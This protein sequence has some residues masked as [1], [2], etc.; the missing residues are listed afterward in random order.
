MPENRGRKR[1]RE[2]EEEGTLDFGGFDDGSDGF[3]QMTSLER[4]LVLTRWDCNSYIGNGHFKPP[5]K[6]AN[7]RSIETLQKK[8]EEPLVPPPKRMEPVVPAPIVVKVEVED[9]NGEMLTDSEPNNAK[10]E[11]EGKE[12]C[13]PPELESPRTPGTEDYDTDVMPILVSEHSN[14][15]TSILDHHNSKSSMPMPTLTPENS[16][17]VITRQSSPSSSNNG[18]Q[19]SSSENQPIGDNESKLGEQEMSI[20]SRLRLAPKMFEDFGILTPF[21]RMLIFTQCGRRGQHSISEDIQGRVESFDDNKQMSSVSKPKRI[22]ETP[23]RN[24]NP[25]S[26]A[27]AT[28]NV[29]SNPAAKKKRRRAPSKAILP[30][31]K[32][33]RKEK[34]ANKNLVPKSSLLHMFLSSEKYSSVTSLVDQFSFL[35]DHVKNSF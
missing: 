19:Q 5:Q 29:S 24:S 31:R 14:S 9:V 13:S 18:F 17:F 35:Q 12:S 15:S 20:E 1:L 27:K 25:R 3:H 2:Q 26:N 30:S 8:S 10:E 16:I 6:V 22:N 4:M 23:K 11:V 33:K 34:K 7:G 32:E 28:T 21:E